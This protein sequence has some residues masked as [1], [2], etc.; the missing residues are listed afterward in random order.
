MTIITGPI[1]PERTSAEKIPV[2]DSPAPP[3]ETLPIEP[4]QKEVPCFTAPA[5]VR[6]KKLSFF[7]TIAAQFLIAAAVGGILWL[8]TSFGGEAVGEISQSILDFLLNV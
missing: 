6:R 8:G 2:S 3:I 7:G 4:E 5:P 1:V